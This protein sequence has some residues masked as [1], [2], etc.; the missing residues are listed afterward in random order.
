MWKLCVGLSVVRW[1]SRGCWDS[2]VRFY[3]FISYH[4][5]HLNDLLYSRIDLCNYI[6]NFTLLK[7]QMT[8]YLLNTI[9]TRNKF[10]A[11]WGTETSVHVQLVIRF[12]TSNIFSTYISF[13]ITP[14]SGLAILDITLNILY[15]YLGVNQIR[16]NI[17]MN[18]NLNNY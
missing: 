13:I 3:L 7:Q 16:N 2:T 5:T 14:I 10:R 17:S 11:F 1:F 9:D 8:F 18:Y 15:Y 4:I 6:F 12:R